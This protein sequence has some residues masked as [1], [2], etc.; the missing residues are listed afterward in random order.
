MGKQALNYLLGQLERLGYPERRDDP[1]D[2][3]S[4]R[5]ALTHG[6]RVPDCDLRKKVTGSN[7]LGLDAVHRPLASDH[8]LISAVRRGKLPV[9]RTAP[10]PTADKSDNSLV[11]SRAL[12]APR[13]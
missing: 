3:R 1:R 9:R 5:I 4:K 10:C 6:Q 13:G 11:V 12:P 8:R 2:Q 7:P